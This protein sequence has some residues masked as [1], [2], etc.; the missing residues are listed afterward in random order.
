MK[1]LIIYFLLMFFA[2]CDNETPKKDKL[3]IIIAENQ[4]TYT[5]D[6]KP[7]LASRCAACHNEDSMPNKNWQKYK[8]A[9]TFRY[10]IKARVVTLKNMPPNN[11]TGML[12]SER[13]TIKKWVDQ[14]GKK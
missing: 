7:I 1:Q 6:L 3:R 2:G 12:E 14:G 11:I 10:N 8:L 9:Y 13:E 4:I 5:K